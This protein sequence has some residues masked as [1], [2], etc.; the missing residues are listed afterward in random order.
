M[1]ISFNDL[2]LNNREPVYQQIIKH[3]KRNILLGNLSDG[4]EI[5]SRRVLAV[6]LGIN[7]NTVQKIYKQLESENLIETLPNSK[8]NIIINSNKIEVIRKELTEQQ[9]KEFLHE[10]KSCG[11]DFKQVIDLIGKT[12]DDS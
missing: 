4:E 2:K 10:L 3:F 11:L 5:P 12:W 1:P 6:T 9:S 8:S 7:P